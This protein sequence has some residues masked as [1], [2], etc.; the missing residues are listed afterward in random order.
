MATKSIKEKNP[1]WKLAGTL[2][3]GDIEKDKVKLKKYRNKLSK[4]IEERY[5]HI[6]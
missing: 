2:S 3:K 1:L 6:I 4:D 5:A